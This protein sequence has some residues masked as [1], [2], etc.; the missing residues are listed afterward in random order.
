MHYVV[1]LIIK[2]WTDQKMARKYSCW[3]WWNKSYE[4]SVAFLQVYCYCKIVFVWLNTVPSKRCENYSAPC[5]KKLNVW[6]LVL[7]FGCRKSQYLDPISQ[8]R[9]MKLVGL[10]EPSTMQMH[11]DGMICICD[12]V[13]WMMTYFNY[14]WLKKI[15]TLSKEE[16][17]KM[18]WKV[19]AQAVRSNAENSCLKIDS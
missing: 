2:K 16:K 12:R 1:L 4:Q 10:D 14:P 17:A 7:F 6:Q 15:N 9:W 18:D 19:E 13:N 3:S 5:Q 8:S 11:G